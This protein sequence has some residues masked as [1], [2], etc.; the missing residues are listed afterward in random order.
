MLNENLRLIKKDI[1]KIQ[2]AIRRNM[3]RNNQRLE[4]VN[5]RRKQNKIEERSAE[6]KDK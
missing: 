6:I 1:S 4:K 2:K 3:K 5:R